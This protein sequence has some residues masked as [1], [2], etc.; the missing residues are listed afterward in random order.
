MIPKGRSAQ[1]SPLPD[2]TKNPFGGR[3]WARNHDTFTLETPVNT[4]VAP[5]EPLGIL[6]AR[7]RLKVHLSSPARR[8]TSSPGYASDGYKAASPGIFRVPGAGTQRLNAR[9]AEGPWTKR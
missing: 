2:P 4:R 9:K 8:V 3:E 7:V 5:D 6:A 1:R